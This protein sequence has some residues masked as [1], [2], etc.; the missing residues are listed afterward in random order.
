MYSIC[1]MSEFQLG[2]RRI[3]V[4]KK[5]TDILTSDRGKIKTSEIRD[6]AEDIH[7][8]RSFGMSPI[9]VASGATTSGLGV[10]R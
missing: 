9:L 1:I 8:L 6:T 3:I 4:I 10:L 2:D 7:R 5:D